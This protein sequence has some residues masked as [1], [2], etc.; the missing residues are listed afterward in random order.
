LWESVW[1][2]L[3]F[4]EKTPAA[5]LKEERQVAALATPSR[6]Q[7]GTAASKPAG[8]GGRRELDADLIR[9]SLAGDGTAARELHRHYYPIVAS[10]LGKLG[11]KPP[12]LEDACQEVFTLFFRHVGTF[13]GEAELT[14]WVFRLCVSEARRARRRRQIGAALA[15]LLRREPPEDVVPPALRSDATVHELARRAL[16]RMTAEQRTAFV[17]FEIEGLPGRQVAE[18]T[19]RSLPSTFRRLYEAQRTFR[20]A[21]GIE[22]PI[23]EG[24]GT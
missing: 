21:L 4:G 20:E 22:P 24:K 3:F 8:A 15:A 10:F 11:T 19:G 2:S 7:V 12:E 16:D 13:R 17:L 9:R 6:L 1:G 14:T 23:E 18:I 5:R